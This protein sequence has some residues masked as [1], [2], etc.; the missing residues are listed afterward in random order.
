MYTHNVSPRRVPTWLSNR[1]W[2]SLSVTLYI[3]IWGL[4]DP[5]ETTTLRVDTLSAT[6]TLAFIGILDSL[7]PMPQK[8]C[9]S[10]TGP[11]S[12]WHWL[13]GAILTAQPSK[14][15]SEHP[16]SVFAGPWIPGKPGLPLCPISCSWSCKRSILLSTCLPLYHLQP[17]ETVC[18]LI[19]GALGCVGRSWLCHR[20]PA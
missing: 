3:V 10:T 15:Y 17:K 16:P 12:S 2:D 9:P 7:K 4:A 13:A 6:Q 19:Q 18:I 14:G 8:Q 20:G 1:H 5:G 11:R